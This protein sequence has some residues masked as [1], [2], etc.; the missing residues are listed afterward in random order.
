MGD[1]AGELHQLGDPED[2]PPRLVEDLAVFP[3]RDESELVDMLVEEG[4]QAVKH[5]N[6]LARRRRRPGREG[7]P[8]AAIASSTSAT[9]HWGVCAITSPVDGS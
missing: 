4:L 7:R 5:L 8:A 1:A 2:V 3:G 9:E 6:A